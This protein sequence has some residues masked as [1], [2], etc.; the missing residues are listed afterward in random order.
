MKDCHWNLF[1]FLK[2]NEWLLA[3][4]GPVRRMQNRYKKCFHVS[5]SESMKYYTT[6]R[7]WLVAS[8]KSTPCFEI[9]MVPLDL[10]MIVRPP[11]LELS[12]TTRHRK[13]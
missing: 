13:R 11:G 7:G 12:G 10:K 4:H 1:L 3:V 6:P 5:Y 2:R 8:C 9:V